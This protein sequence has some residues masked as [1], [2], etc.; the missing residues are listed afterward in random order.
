LYQTMQRNILQDNHLHTMVVPWEPERAQQISF[1]VRVRLLSNHTAVSKE[2]T[3]L[4][5]E[6]TRGQ[7]FVR[8]SSNA[9]IVWVF[10]KHIVM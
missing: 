4:I 2:D 1:T 7:P 10:E 9:K 8:I 3:R 6:Q 5:C